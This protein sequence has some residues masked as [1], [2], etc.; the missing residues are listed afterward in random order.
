MQLP[1]ISAGKFAQ[2]DYSM[3]MDKTSAKIVQGAT[4]NNIQSVMENAPKEDIIMTIPFN[5]RSLT[6]TTSSYVEI[7]IRQS[8]ITIFTII[9]PA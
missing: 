3:I 4:A 9:K 2:A 5:E 6:W 8:E 7:K 1:L